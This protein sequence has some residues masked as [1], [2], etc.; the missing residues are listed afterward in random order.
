MRP[1]SGGLVFS[2]SA[3]GGLRHVAVNVFPRER[4]CKY[5]S[6]YF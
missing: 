1:A 4:A 5:I 3:Y 6:F 2:A